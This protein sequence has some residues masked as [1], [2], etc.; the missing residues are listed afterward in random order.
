[1]TIVFT[2]SPHQPDID[3]LF[4]SNLNANQLSFTHNRS[5]QLVLDTYG[6]KIVINDNTNWSH[7]DREGGY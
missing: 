6:A 2:F 7:K 5:D 4:V 1:M 3:I